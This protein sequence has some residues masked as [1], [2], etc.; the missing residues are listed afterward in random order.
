VPSKKDNTY[1]MGEGWAA[2][3][4]GFELLAATLFG[5]AVGWLIDQWRG[6]Y[7]VGTAIG[8]GLGAVIGM[9]HFVRAALALQRKM[10]SQQ[11]PR[12]SAATPPT[13]RDAGDGSGSAAAGGRRANV[14]PEAVDPAT[15]NNGGGG[16]GVGRRATWFERSSPPDE[17]PPEGPWLDPETG[18]PLGAADEGPLAGLDEHDDTARPADRSGGGAGDARERR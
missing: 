3:G 2:I 11:G 8:G 9:Y 6:S 1:G 4:L 15:A 14:S 5:V 17:D 16:P 18:G 7:P 10:G 12:R 13:E